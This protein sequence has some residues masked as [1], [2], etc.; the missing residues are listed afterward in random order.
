MVDDDAGARRLTRA[1]LDRAG[2]EVIEAANGALALEQLQ[3]SLPD[4][5]LMDVSM[6]VMNGFDACAALRAL[7]GGHRVPVTMITG[8]DDTGSIE[9]A[10]EVGATDFITKP[11]S[12][13]VLPH[14]VRYMLR[15]SVAINTLEQHQ[16]R[17]SNAQRIAEM[18]DW[19]WDVAADRL[20]LSDQ[21]WLLCGHAESPAQPTLAGFLQAVPPDEM[22]RVLAA[23][24]GARTSGE[25][26]AIDHRFK[27]PGGGFRHV[28]QQVEVLSRDADGRARHMAGAVHDIT[29]RKD[30]EE[31]IRRLAYYDSLTGLPNRLLF[32]EQVSRAIAHAGRHEQ[33]LAVIF[34]DLDNFKRVNDTLGHSAGDELLRSTSTRLSQVLRGQDM[35]SRHAEDSGHSIARLGGDE[36]IVLLN[37]LQRPEDAALVAQRLV[38]ALAQPMMVQG[39]EVF[40]GGSLGVAIYPNDGNDVETLMMH[41]DTAMYRAKAGGRSGFQLYDPSMNARALDRLNLETQL[42]RALQRREFVL[43]Y[44]P[45]VDVLSGRIIGAEALIRW[46]HP[47]RGLVPPNDFIPAVEDSGLVIPIGEWAIEEVCRQIAAW[48]DAGMVPVQ[49]AV[50]LASTHLREPALPG[51]VREALARHGV[52]AQLLGIE[53]TESILLTDPEVSIEI[54]RQLC[55]QGVQLSIDDFG[56]GYSSLSY[57]KRLPIASLK[58]DRSFVRDLDTDPDDEAIV[59]AIIALAHSLKLRVVAEGVETPSQLAF[60]QSHRCDEYQGFLTSRAVVPVEFEALLCSSGLPK[61]APLAA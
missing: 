61:E 13:S 58:I 4:L 24:E 16:R 47:E 14:R 57:L 43:H 25:G 48:R 42:R 18:G 19:E 27:L 53:V 29:R 21:S 1:T 37:G 52:P 56:T 36:F 34:I 2:F 44:Q 9:R 39:T 6:P 51:L 10:F 45:R 3:Q 5:V 12:W 23:F 41:A 35:L 15:A 54:A 20:T 8:L 60:L 46:Q 28:Q 33:Q 11:I 22:D 7:P 32:L 38:A 59:S 31:Q 40:V 26:F 30:A 50:N 55:A 49:V 17:L